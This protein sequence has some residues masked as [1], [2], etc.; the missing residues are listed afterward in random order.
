MP[1]KYNY[2]EKTG[3]PTDYSEEILK[4][5]RKY[6]EQAQDEDEQQV[7]GLSAKGTELYKNK[8]RVNLPTI[9]GLSLY[10]GISRET[11]YDWASQKEKKEFSDIIERLRAK[12]AESL[13]NKGLSGDYNSTIAKLILNKH[14]YRDESKQEHD[15]SP[16]LKE[17]LEKANK[18]LP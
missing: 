6:L 15:V 7:I 11:I 10:L 18:I 16:E 12:Q 8:L 14:G 17:L 1:K 2:K 5:A 4:E 9:E 13:L 3:R